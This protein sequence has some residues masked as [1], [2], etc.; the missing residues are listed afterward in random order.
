MMD[1]VETFKRCSKCKNAYYCSREC[2]VADWK[3]H[4]ST[5]RETVLQQKQPTTTASKVLCKLGRHLAQQQEEQSNQAIALD[6][7]NRMLQSEAVPVIESA[8]GSQS[9]SGT[10]K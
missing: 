6:E 10:L 2:Q 7:T 9:L 8:A 1:L 3:E 5:C 4:T